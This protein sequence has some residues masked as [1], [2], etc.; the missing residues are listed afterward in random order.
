MCAQS[1]G[2][3]PQ[4]VTP[5]LWTCGKE[6]QNKSSAAQVTHRTAKEQMGVKK[7]CAQRL[8]DFPGGHTSRRFL[9]FPLEPLLETF[10]TQSFGRCL[11]LRWCKT[12]FIQDESMSQWVIFIW[13]SP[14]VTG[15]S[16]PPLLS[17]LRTLLITW[18][19]WE[20]YLSLIKPL[21]LTLIT[22]KGMFDYFRKFC[23]AREDF[24][25]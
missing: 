15:G 9:L 7:G 2:F 12:Y 10:N 25:L 17:S 4:W 24:S 19:L 11:R 5:V 16:L 18:R 13:L 1:G 14:V 3:G 8:N 20:L 23:V 21:N 6:P 22:T